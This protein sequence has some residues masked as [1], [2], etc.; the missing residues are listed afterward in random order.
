MAPAMHPRRVSSVSPHA[1]GLAQAMVSLC[2]QPSGLR[3]AAVRW[4]SR[5]PTAEPR[6]L[7]GIGQETLI[8]SFAAPAW[9]PPLMA[10]A[11]PRAYQTACRARMPSAVAVWEVRRSEDAARARLWH[12]QQTLE[13]RHPQRAAHPG[14]RPRPELPPWPRGGAALWKAMAAWRTA[15]RGRAPASYLEAQRSRPE[16]AGASGQVPAYGPARPAARA[17]P[18]RGARAKAPAR[19]ACSG[20]ASPPTSPRPAHRESGA[21]PPPANL[22]RRSCSCRSTSAPRDQDRRLT[23]YPI[24]HRLSSERAGGRLVPLPSPTPTS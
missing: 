18:Q 20:A 2:V 3:S 1:M 16:W 10:P 14:V 12:S 24:H 7:A 8:P 17:A 23:D 5:R 15:P 13:E 21:D 19:R 4:L 11:Q 22:H 9:A 6:A